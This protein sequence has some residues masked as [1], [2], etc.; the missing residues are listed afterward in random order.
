MSFGKQADNQS[1]VS[2]YLML[3]MHYLIFEN[4][5]EYNL[6]IFQQMMS[7]LTRL[8][9]QTHWSLLLKLAGK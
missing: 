9:F 8:H 4:L 7:Y 6:F 1:Y 5:I 3:K 2:H